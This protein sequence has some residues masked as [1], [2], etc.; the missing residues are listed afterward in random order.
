MERTND[1]NI[2]ERI[3]HLLCLRTCVQMEHLRRCNLNPMSICAEP[4]G[5]LHEQLENQNR[6]GELLS[7]ACEGSLGK[8]LDKSLSAIHVA[9]HI[10]TKN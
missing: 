2:H 10:L 6:F 4:N 5:F 8:Q 9:E 7:G 3:Q 1:E